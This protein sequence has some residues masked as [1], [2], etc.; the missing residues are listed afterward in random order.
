[1]IELRLTRT[2]LH[3]L[4]WTKPVI[5][6]ATEYGLSDVGLA[7]ACR[8]HDIPLPPVGYWAKVAAGQ[9][10][11]APKL[12]GNGEE[13]VEFSGSPSLR[14]TPLS[15]TLKASLNEALASRA[16]SGEP[17]DVATLA[18]W[19]RKTARALERR[20]DQGG[21]I[22]GKADT[23]S[24][25]ISPDTKERVIRILN[26]IETALS[27][28]GVEW[29][30]SEKHHCAVGKLLDQTLAF[31]ISESATRTE[32]IKKHPLY[33]WRNEKSYT[34]DFSGDLTLR[35]AGWYDG[36]K[37]WADGKTQR[38]EEKLSQVIEGFLAAAEA[39]RRKTEEQAEQHRKWAEEAE[40]RRQMEIAER[41]EREF[42]EAALKEANTW[43]QANQLRQYVQH[44]R[45]TIATNKIELTEYGHEW[46]R[47]AE[48]AAERLDPTKQWRGKG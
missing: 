20:P 26:E 39:M 30:Q 40:I 24:V 36:R 14:K 12:R 42:L 19:T 32:H 10:M 2:E 38:L 28:A 3:Q 5:H 44:L 45:E 18:R 7:K 47:Q 23:F 46:L 1:M 34:Y 35:I 37:S 11:P 31:D 41:K 22:H 13:I 9:Q 29:E 6:L 33:D 15:P 16:L 48:A 17:V 4:V 21:W 27:S 25:R 8:R 43:Q